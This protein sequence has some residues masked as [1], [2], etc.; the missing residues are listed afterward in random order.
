MSGYVRNVEVR[1]EFDGQQVRLVMK[2]LL[3]VDLFKL[4]ALLPRGKDASQMSDDEAGPAFEFYAE[5][6]P[7]YVIEANVTDAAGAPVPVAEWVSSSYFV[8]LVSEVMV[9]HMAKASPSRP[10]SS[11]APPAASSG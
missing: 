7:D 8:G 4:Q 5:R 6:L 1:V 9:E 11:G 10:L 3:R 2:P